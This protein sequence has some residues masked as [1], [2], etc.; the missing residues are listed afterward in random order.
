MIPA[1]AA[2]SREARGRGGP[3]W[4]EVVH[5]LAD[6]VDADHVA[7]DRA[8]LPDHPVDRQALRERP[9]AR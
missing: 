7:D 8:R 4:A 6:D 5:V 1:A 2:R 9:P 3:E